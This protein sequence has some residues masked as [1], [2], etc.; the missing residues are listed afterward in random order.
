MLAFICPMVLCN[1]C[2][3]I[4]LVSHMI[5]GFAV[6]RF[7]LMLDNRKAKLKADSLLLLPR[8]RPLSFLLTEVSMQVK[9]RDVSFLTCRGNRLSCAKACCF[10]FEYIAV[11]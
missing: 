1:I 6:S 7:A 11:A 9:K 2:F 5:L 3:A 4:A 8:I 10:S